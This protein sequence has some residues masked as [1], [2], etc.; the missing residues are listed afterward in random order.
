MA[1]I[2]SIHPGLFTDEAFATIS[3]AARV[4]LMGIWTECDDH[5]VFEWKPVT[6]KMRIMPA[7]NVDIPN[8]LAELEAAGTIKRFSHGKDY[9]LVRNFCRYQ[10]PKSPKYVHSIPPEFYTYVG[11]NPDGSLPR[12]KQTGETS[13]PVENQLPTSSEKP[14]QR[15]EGGGNKEEGIGNGMGE[16]ASAPAPAK[17]SDSSSGRGQSGDGTALTLDFSPS[18]VCRETIE[19][20]GFAEAQFNS[21]FSKFV[22]YYMARGYRRAD[23]NAALV[24]WFQRAIPEAKP[25]LPAVDLAIVNK[26]FVVE[27]TLEWTCW[28]QH[29]KETRGVGWSRTIARHDEHG[30]TQNGWW[31]PTRFPPGYDEA[32]GERLEGK[33]GEAA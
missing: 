22:A 12:L 7:D 20:M 9:G 4:L 25:S 31:R 28:S 10:R 21:E 13:E 26:V 14:P 18:P 24:S 3:M 15:E 27:G 32:T 16:G 33:N 30:H 2:R 17:R 5:G 1:R 8:L 29:W 6:L 23:W 11:L 19:A